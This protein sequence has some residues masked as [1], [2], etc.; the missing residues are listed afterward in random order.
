MC[1]QS[2]KIANLEQLSLWID[3]HAF[4]LN[5]ITLYCNRFREKTE[6][7]CIS[8]S[9]LY[10]IIKDFCLFQELEFC[11]QKLINLANCFNVTETPLK[12]S[13]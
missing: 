7:S 3:D 12:D 10:C 2:E 13:D 5:T 6:A 1:Q 8:V 11:S 4:I 9:L